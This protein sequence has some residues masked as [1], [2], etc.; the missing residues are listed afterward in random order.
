MG[1]R[2]A[3]DDQQGDDWGGENKGG[4]GNHGGGIDG[5]PY[6]SRRVRWVDEALDALRRGGSAR[7]EGSGRDPGG[8]HG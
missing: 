5:P 7:A 6:R 2:A 4:G 1:W 8:S 3:G